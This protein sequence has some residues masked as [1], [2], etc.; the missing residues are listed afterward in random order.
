M[1]IGRTNAGGCGTGARLT[2]S[3]PAGVTVTVAKDGKTKTRTANG[4]GVAVFRG[5]DSGTWEITISDGQKTATKNVEIV[6]EYT[7]TMAFFSAAI[8]VTFPEGS[9]CTCSDGSTTLE[10]TDTSGSYTFT[11]PNAG[12]WTVTCKDGEDTASAEVVISADGES[13][14]VEL[15]YE[16]YLY[17]DGKRN[18]AFWTKAWGSKNGDHYANAPDV[19]YNEDNMV[20]REASSNQYRSG[21]VHTSA[22]VDLTK[23]TTLKFYGAG[24]STNNGYTAIYIWEDL[25]GTYFDSQYAARSAFT[26]EG[27]ALTTVDV[28]KLTGSYYIGFMVYNGKSITLRRLSLK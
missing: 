15:D 20:I 13:K 5:L 26:A 2:V 28:S 27:E 14:S 18:V 4:S 12:T 1:A 8:A 9:S 6:A 24:G 16:T 22:K 19:T 10:A 11:V 3:A 21:V 25:S 7:E 17:K 23:A